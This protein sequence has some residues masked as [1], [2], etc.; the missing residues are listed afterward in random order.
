MADPTLPPLP[1]LLD[2]PDT[3]LHEIELKSL[4]LAAQCMKRAKQEFEQAVAYRERAG[5]IRFLINGRDEMLNL[6]RRTVDG[7]QGLL[8]FPEVIEQRET[9]RRA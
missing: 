7:K 8:L 2:C 4:D 6:A 9:R 5:A 3:A 1:Y